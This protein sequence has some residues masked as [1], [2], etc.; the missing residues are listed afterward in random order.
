[1]ECSG[2][3]LWTHRQCLLVSS[4]FFCFLGVKSC[5]FLKVQVNLTLIQLLQLPERHLFITENWLCLYDATITSNLATVKQVFQWSYLGNSID[6][7][8]APPYLLLFRP[9]VDDDINV[10]Q[11]KAPGSEFLSHWSLG[12]F[13]SMAPK[14]QQYCDT[15]SVIVIW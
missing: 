6:Y 10:I 8:K 9:Q 15:R 11:G 5:L 13:H 1:M 14:I 12:L 4:F 7:K 3:Y 2:I